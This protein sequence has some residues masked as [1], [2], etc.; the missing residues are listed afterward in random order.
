MERAKDISAT[1]AAALSGLTILFGGVTAF[2]SFNELE[3]KQAA[4]GGV[5][6]TQDKLRDE[7]KKA[8]KE[9]D[10]MQARYQKLCTVLGYRDRAVPAPPDGKTYTHAFSEVSAANAVVDDL[11]LAQKEFGYK[12]ESDKDVSG[13]V[14]KYPDAF[15]DFPVANNH[16]WER[17]NKSYRTVQVDRLLTLNQALAAFEALHRAQQAKYD[18]LEK[19]RKDGYEAEVKIV[20][21]DIGTPKAKEGEHSKM[22]KELTGQA[23]QKRTDCEGLAGRIKT[24]A[25][26]KEADIASKDKEIKAKLEKRD[27]MM[28]DQAKAI[29]I[30]E[31]Q[32]NDF[33]GRIEKIIKREEL[34]RASSEFDGR[35]T[36]VVLD[37][38]YAY[39][40]I[41]SEQTLLKG[42]RFKVFGTLKGGKKVEKGEVEVTNI[43]SNYAQVAILSTLHPELPLAVGDYINNDVYDPKKAKVFAFAGRFVGKYSNEDAKSKI[44]EMGGKVMSDVSLETTYLVVGDGYQSHPN[45]AKASELGV[46]VIRE[47]DLYE[48]LG[49][50]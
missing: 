31:K 2:M 14:A 19:E 33:K 37:Q 18:A 38:A 29:A 40:D 48:L 16:L 35:I 21:T 41:G 24:Q 27:Q 9:F 25:S 30:I 3:N 23:D 26:E 20:G 7:Y 11:L 44:E 5:R 4:E 36:H 22:E 47:K 28:G 49:I 42:T 12:D 46:L 17:D 39:I 43:F 10:T 34:A 1:I 6:K 15:K 32:I 50:R 45:Y 8:Q 13:W